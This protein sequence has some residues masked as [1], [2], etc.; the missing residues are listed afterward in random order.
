MIITQQSWNKKNKKQKEER[1]DCKF[2]EELGWTGSTFLL[3]F[4]IKSLGFRN[5]FIFIW[6]LLK[7]GQFVGLLILKVGR[8][9]SGK[10]LKNSIALHLRAFNFFRLKFVIND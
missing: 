3:A 1:Q 2:A 5:K 7:L 9:E 4:F 10:I 6:S 8:R